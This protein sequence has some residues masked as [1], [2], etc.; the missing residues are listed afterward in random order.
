MRAR[1]RVRLSI[2]KS[3]LVRVH[4]QV[5]KGALRDRKTDEFIVAEDGIVFIDGNRYA[6][7]YESEGA[8]SEDRGGPLQD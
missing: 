2:P 1:Y 6:I 7:W 3:Q 4:L 5:M 8:L